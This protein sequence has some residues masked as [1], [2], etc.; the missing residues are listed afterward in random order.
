MIKVNDEELLK[1]EN[2]KI[3]LFT[4]ELNEVVQFVTNLKNKIEKEIDEINNLY[5]DVKSKIIIKFKEEHE[6]LIKEE[7]N[8]IEKLQNEVTKTKEKLENFLSNI[9]ELIR[10]NEKIN[11][12][13]K[14]F[15]KE[16]EKIIIKDLSY[17]S[18][19]TKNKKEIISLDAKLMNNIKISLNKEKYDINYDNYYFNGIYIPKNFEFKTISSSSVQIFWKIDDFNIENLDKNKIIFK[20]EIKKKNV[21]EKFVEIYENIDNKCLIDNLDINTYYDI[22]ICCKYNYLIG[23]WSEINTF[24]TDF[25]TE[26][27]ILSQEDKNKLL[28]WLNPLIL[29][30]KFLLEL[31]YR[32]GN[33]MS[34]KTFH[35]KCD[36]KGPTIVICK[37]KSEKFGGYTNIS[38]ESLKCTFK[39]IEGPF[40]FSINKNK[41]FD[42]CNKKQHS[43]CL[44][45]NNG[46]DFNWDFVFNS[47]NEMKTCKCS[48]KDYGYA[49]SNEPIVGDGTLKD[50]EI[51]EVEVFKFKIN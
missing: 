26:S 23:P 50:I 25:I 16:G 30:K 14:I 44:N 46:P 21:K 2:I 28:N 33:D 8:L 48:T 39:F 17:I 36:N 41:K 12:G 40:I 3:E 4:K 42:Y 34:V 22:R 13:I 19:I 18:S 49:Y 32:R 6:K 7:N 51:D 5:N 31:I 11:K 15:Q 35:L 38:W 1:K 43:I 24:K 47:K 45:A 10:I 37:A 9:N 29:G 20:V 27:K